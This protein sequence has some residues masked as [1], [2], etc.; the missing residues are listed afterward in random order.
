MQKRFHAFFIV[1]PPCENRTHG[2]REILLL[3]RESVFVQR[4]EFLLRQFNQWDIRRRGMNPKSLQQHLELAFEHLA[5]AFAK[6][7]FLTAVRD[8][9]TGKYLH[10]GWS[11]MGSS[12][13]IHE[14]LRSAHHEIFEDVSGLP[15]AQLCAE[16]ERYFHSLA[17]PLQPTACL[18]NEL[19]SYREMVP[20]GICPEGREL[21]VSQMRAAL[22]ILISAPDWPPRQ[23]LVSWRLPQPDQQFP[24]HLEN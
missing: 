11:S 8:S 12:E 6:L 7:A 9:Y 2:N 14:L 19:E 21:F 15:I 10:E 4:T 3:S 16:L 20:E 13:E 1:V 23:E 22:A 18:W 24:H 5:T 17:T